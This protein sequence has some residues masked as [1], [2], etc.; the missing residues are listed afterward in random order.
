MSSHATEL[1]FCAKPFSSS[2]CCEWEC[3]SVAAHPGSPRRRAV[4][5]IRASATSKWSFHWSTQDPFMSSTHPS[6]F[7]TTTAT[8]R[9]TNFVFYCT[10]LSLFTSLS[11]LMIIQFAFSVLTLLVGRQKQH[12]ACKNWVTRCWCGYLPAARC[13]LA[14]TV[15]DP[16]CPLLPE[17]WQL[18]CLRHIH[19]NRWCHRAALC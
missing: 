16:S 6:S 15:L 14:H 10:T 8:S 5:W 17:L 19:S 3:S 12:P 9:F 2:L 1:V 7:S 18:H 13:R 4:K 11:V